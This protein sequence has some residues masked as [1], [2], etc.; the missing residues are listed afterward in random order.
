MDRQMELASK[1]V[2]GGTTAN[3][4]QNSYL[5]SIEA[6]SR[7]HRNIHK[8]FFAITKKLNKLFPISTAILASCSERDQS[9]KI[10]DI[11]K[12]GHTGEALGLILSDKDSLLYSVC[13]S[14]II[15]WENQPRELRTN[16]LE[17]KLLIDSETRSLAIC[18]IGENGYVSGL[19][20]FASP[21]PV[22]MELQDTNLLQTIIREFSVG[23]KNHNHR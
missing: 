6:L 10:I 18:P 5:R 1:T 15:F 12:A 2:I 17:R 20:C 16:F 19:F 11:K 21:A 4:R 7:K 9:L 3:A 13:R 22:T 14:R 23:L 8:L